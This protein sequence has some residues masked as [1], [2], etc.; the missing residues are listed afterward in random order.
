MHIQ[1]RPPWPPFDP[2][3]LRQ[4]RG[5]GRLVRQAFT[6]PPTM[7]LLR[8]A[9]RAPRLGGERF[10]TRYDDV[11]EALSQPDV[12][13]VPWTEKMRS[14]SPSTRPFVLATDDAAAHR[15][16]QHPL[17]QVFRHEDAPRVACIAA[18]AADQIVDGAVSEID[19][20]KDLI[21]V[22]SRDVYRDY[23]GLHALD[24]DF[25][26]WLLAISNYTFRRVG[27]DP[28]PAAARGARRWCRGCPGCRG[29]CRPRRGP[30]SSAPSA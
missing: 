28:A 4:E 14:L 21:S 2:Q 8:H 25:I 15:C 1:P 18:R 26:P 17:M 3:A 9:P 24:D 29:A 5:F 7:W 12:F 6:W 10:V 27:P 11:R 13:Q 30:R 22:V 20:L 23:Y 16:A 19:A